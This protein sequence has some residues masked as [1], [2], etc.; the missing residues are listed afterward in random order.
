MEFV[1][2]SPLSQEERSPEIRLPR[3]G[4]IFKKLHNGQPF[5]KT[6][7]AQ[8]FMRI[9]TSDFSLKK[10]KLPNLANEALR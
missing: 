7:S 1:Q 6:I 10:I 3:L 8:E 4:H 9:L 5:P 2:N